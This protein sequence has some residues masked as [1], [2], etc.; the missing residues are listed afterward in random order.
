M[1]TLNLN[2]ENVN[3]DANAKKSAKSLKAVKPSSKT[4][5]DDFAEL[6]GSVITDFKIKTTLEAGK[7]HSVQLDSIEEGVSASGSPKL[8]FVFKDRKGGVAVETLSFG[9]FEKS[10]FTFNRVKY[11]LISHEDKMI[12]VGD[13]EYSIKSLIAH[14]DGIYTSIINSALEEGTV[15][16]VTSDID[17]DEELSA[18]DLS[19][20]EN[21][22]ER[23]AMKKEHKDSIIAAYNA[24]MFAK[25]QELRKQGFQI[26]K[27]KGSK[28]SYALPVDSK[29]LKSIFPIAKLIFPLAIKSK[30]IISLKQEGKFVNVRSI[31]PL[32][33]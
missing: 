5:T 29:V 22:R 33:V 4:A 9:D 26:Y 30:F 27:P 17:R 32:N 7:D 25:Y 19:L 1:E 24:D 28:Q 12:K 16:K 13:K 11:L 2:L 23:E 20:A 15:I 31:T 18:D 8:T 14:I 21:E 10:A 3:D 6:R